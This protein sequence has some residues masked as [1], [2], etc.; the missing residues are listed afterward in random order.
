M[1]IESR[2]A[3]MFLSEAKSSLITLQIRA[4]SSTAFGSRSELESGR[5]EK[6]LVAGGES[7]GRR[8]GRSSLDFSANPIR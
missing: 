7:G 2:T 8:E 5:E 4:A 3:S 6:T 1:L